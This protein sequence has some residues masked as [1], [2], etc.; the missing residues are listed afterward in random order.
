VVTKSKEIGQILIR[1]DLWHNFGMFPSPMKM[2]R[3]WIVGF[4]S[5]LSLGGWAQTEIFSP[6][7]DALKA[8]SAK[9]LVKHFKESVDIDL[10]GDERTYSKAQ[11]ELVLRDFFK[12]HA[13][14]DFSIIHDGSSKGGLQY[15]IGRYVS[16]PEN[17]YVIIRVKE[18]EGL[19]LIHEIKF[20]KE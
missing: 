7:K 3:I 1:T 8:G 9:E 16:G 12:K 6:M 14:T 10:D 4:L 13:V 20:R 5:V 2:K 15:A 19:H 11:A 17:Y 18:E